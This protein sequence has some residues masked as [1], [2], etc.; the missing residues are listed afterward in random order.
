MQDTLPLAKI[1]TTFRQVNPQHRSNTIKKLIQKYKN[2]LFNTKFKLLNT[3]NGSLWKTTKNLLKLKKFS[4]PIKKSD[5]SLALSDLD[6]AN[7]FGN[8]SR[9]FSQQNIIPN[10]AHLDKINKFIDAPLPMSLQMKFQ[11]LYKG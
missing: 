5:G 11:I 1:K 3:Q 6:K 7:L 9:I 2:D 8:I 10:T 4:S